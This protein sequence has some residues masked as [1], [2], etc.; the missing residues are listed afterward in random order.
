MKAFIELMTT[1]ARRAVVDIASIK[2]I[3]TADGCDVLTVASPDHPL[4]LLLTD[5]TEFEVYGISVEQL[6]VQL[7][8]YNRID[9]CLWLPR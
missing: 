1:K 7:Q 4:T 9:G 6:I 5:G 3:F 2:A 8:S